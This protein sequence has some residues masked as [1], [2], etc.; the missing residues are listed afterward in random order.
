MN[1]SSVLNATTSTTNNISW[2]LFSIDEEKGSNTDHCSESTKQ[3]SSELVEEETTG[4]EEYL[5]LR[6]FIAN[7]TLVIG[8]TL[9]LWFQ[10][11]MNLQAEIGNL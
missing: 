10:I 6:S 3:T 7:F 1:I 4:V 8:Y 5:N 11:F 9:G 2:P